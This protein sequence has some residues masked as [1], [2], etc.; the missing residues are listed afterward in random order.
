MSELILDQQLTA[1]RQIFAT[2]ETLR[3]LLALRPLHDENVKGLILDALLKLQEAHDALCTYCETCRRY[4]H[5]EFE[6]E[7]PETTRSGT[8]VSVP[9]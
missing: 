4:G 2:Q 8:P 3:T 5:F 1:R 7:C 6:A 9:E